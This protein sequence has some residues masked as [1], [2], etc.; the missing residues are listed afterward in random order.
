MTRCQTLATAAEA[1]EPL[2]LAQRISARGLYVAKYRH[3]SEQLHRRPSL[4]HAGVVEARQKWTRGQALRRT[5]DVMLESSAA[6]VG[7]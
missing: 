7:V 6:M 5:L 2:T 4:S 3:Q 1:G